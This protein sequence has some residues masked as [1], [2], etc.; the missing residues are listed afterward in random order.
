MDRNIDFYQILGVPKN[1][2]Q[3]E[4]KNAYRKQVI[5]YHPDKNQNP[6]APEK[7]RKI[8]IAYETL[9]DN[10]KKVKY[11]SFDDLPYNI[12]TK[13]LFLYYQELII[14]LCEKY[15]INDRQ[16]EELVMLFNPGDYMEE[17]K[18]NNI[19]AANNKMY[20]KITEYGSKIFWKKI[21]ENQLLVGFM[22]FIILWFKRA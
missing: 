22:E 17:L 1:A 9:T 14:E 16:K 19:I 20:K 4:I 21:S 6:D 12:E 11:D 8:Q 3:V 5:K 2:T 13:N 18:N 7:F 15:E 10:N